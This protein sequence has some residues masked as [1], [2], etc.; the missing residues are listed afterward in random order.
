MVNADAIR[1]HDF[2]VVVDPVN[3]SGGIAVPALLKALG[4]KKIHVIN[5][6]PDG[7]FAH[8]PEPL[9]DHL[10][11]LAAEVVRCKADLG[12]S[13]DPDVDRLALVNED[14]TFFG[15]EYTLVAVADYIMSLKKGH[16]VS[17]LSSSRAL[18][19][20]A[21]KHGGT[22]SA[23][24]VGE[25]NVVAEMKKTG[26]VIGGEGN[27]GIIVPEL[28]YGRDALAGIALFLSHL[29]LSGKKMSEFRSMYPTLEMAKKKIDL[30]PETDIDR[31][32]DSM[33]GLYS[34]YP[35]NRS[36]G[37]KIDFPTKWIHLRKSN[38]EPVIRVY[39]EAP[40]L[41]EAESLA[42]LAL[43]EIRQLVKN[44]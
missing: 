8:N 25:V 24:P 38:T 37:L 27:G 42:E 30:S 4:V 32:L 43:Q 1:K 36:D 35:Q 28:H 22:Y 15:E 44:C 31:I 33:A 17:N 11:E 9:P 2:S 7:R 21:E 34:A 10:T 39:T 26:A 5:G 18:G 40:T 41:K 20:I 19:I 6:T 23:T 16:A 12:I 14:G 3:S 13:V 29:A